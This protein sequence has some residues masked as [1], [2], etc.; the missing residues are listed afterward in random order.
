MDKDGRAEGTVNECG[1]EAAIKVI[2][3]RLP[4]GRCKKDWTPRQTYK[5]VNLLKYKRFV[6]PFIVHGGTPWP[7][8]GGAGAPI[9]SDPR[10]AMPISI[11]V[12]YP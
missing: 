2:P 6:C 1:F 9:A 10:G 4:A 8:E 3:S 7:S 5:N 12:D 11:L